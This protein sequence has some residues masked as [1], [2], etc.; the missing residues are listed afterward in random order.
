MKER[1]AVGMSG[2]VDSSVAALLLRDAGYDVVGI[3]LSL[4]PDSVQSGVQD[5]QAVAQTLEIEHHVL[6]LREDFRRFVTEPFMESYLHGQTPNPCVLCNQTIKFG[7]MLRFAQTLDAHRIATGH[8]AKTVR[9]NGRTLLYRADSRK[10]QSY[11]LCMLSQSQLSAAVFPLAQLE[12]ET[13]RQ[14]AENKGLPV[15]RKKDSQDVCFIPDNDYVSYICQNRGI[16][17]QAGDFVDIHGH[18]LG[19]HQGILR[20]TV[21]QRKGLGAFG[22]PMF[23]TRIDPVQNRVILGENG[24]QYAA[25]LRADSLNWIAFDTPPSAFDCCVRIRFRAADAPARVQ[26]RDGQALVRF[27]Q[28]QRS[29]TPG[30][31]VAFYNGDLV[32]GGGVI[33]EAL[34][35]EED[36]EET[37]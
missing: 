2:G 19:Q 17:P 27:A 10:D 33:Q 31:T 11:F 5:A 35:G 29:V 32:L 36:D 22:R 9:K 16:A 3:T 6:D 37:L 7:A 14:I 15:A 1:I 24:Q 28:P 21:G 25:A 13:L 20:Y 4:V 30:Q 12:K 34:Q 23:V 8:Y 26:I 18:V